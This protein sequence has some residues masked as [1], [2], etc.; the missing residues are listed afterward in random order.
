VNRSRNILLILAACLLLG[1]LLAAQRRHLADAFSL[2]ASVPFENLSKAVRAPDGSYAA[3]FDSNRRIA[4]VDPQ[5]E[6]DYLLA[7]RNNPDKGF[8]FANEIAFA[9][10][11]TL[12]VAST[13]I[14]TQTLAVNREAILRFSPEGRHDGVLHSIDHAPEAYVDNTGLFRALEWT[15][16]GLRLCIV[17]EGAI[18]ALLL[19]P[20]SGK[21]LREATHPLPDD[22]H[23][24]IDAAIV[25]DD[26]RIAFTTAA[27]E[28]YAASPGDA[29]AKLY[30]GREL[31]DDLFSIPANVRDD[32]DGVAFSDLGRDA[33]LRLLPDGSAVP[34]FDAQ[35]AA[36]AGY[37]DDY[38]ECKSFQLQADRLVL[39][40][41]GKIVDLR[42]LPTPSVHVLD[43]ARIN[44]S[45]WARRGAIWLQ[46]ALLAVLLIVLAVLAA[47]GS[48]PRARHVAG[49]IALV[50]AMIA[51]A[52]GVTTYMIFKNMNHRIAQEAADNL[53]GYLEVG[54]I[55]LDAD[56]VDRIRHVKHYGNDDYQAILRQLRQTITREGAI[57]SSTYSGVYK[58]VNGRLAALA[59][60][61]GL[62][63]IFYPY[64]YRYA[65]SV[66]AK[67]AAT[68]QP[69]LG[70]IVDQYGVWL[71]GVVPLANAQGEFVGF[72]EVGIDQSARHEANRSLIRQTLADLA[73]ILFVLLFVFSEIGFFTSHVLDPAARRDDDGRRRYDEGAIRFVSFLAIAGVF[74]SASFLPLFSKSLARPVGSL[75]LD[76][77]VGMPM[78][79]ETLCGA[80]VA[81][82]YG[83]VRLRLGLKT[84][85]VLACLVVAAGMA[86]TAAASSF[87]WL[88]AAR[89]VVGMGMG[90]LMIA[91]RT[92]FLIEKNELRKE[93]GIVAL[94][95]GVVAGIN[96]GSVAGGM[97]AA[98][99]GMTFV[100]YLQVAM[101]LLAAA[102]AIVLVRNRKRPAPQSGSAAPALSSFAFLRDRAVWTFFLFAFMPITACGL[103]LGFLFPLF[104]E[105]QGL[106][107]NEISLAFMLFGA[108]SV[109][110]GPAMTRLTSFLFGPRASIPVGALVM[111]AALLLFAAFQS[112]PAAYAAI[113]LFGLTDCFVFNQGMSYFAAL[114][115]VRRFG[116]DKA[117]GVYNVFESGGEALGPLAFGLAMAL[118]LG[119][120]IA[121]IAAT[122]GAC[123]ALFWAFGKPSTKDAP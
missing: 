54:R 68:G 11:G 70:E 56:A 83:H 113:A 104:A 1:G 17:R 29:P 2:A 16:A 123:A 41:N 51:A 31:P 81:L 109:Y 110:L 20:A 122:L 57:D 86:A 107:T 39:P 25:S 44:L 75:P 61:D 42:L 95:A 111:V 24:V 96:A 88:F 92:Y 72:L 40:N 121:A 23:D 74:L 35:I 50:A 106:S 9:P 4:K 76:L 34:L 77:L 91:F 117:M 49:Q 21:I 60:H 37:A 66:Y 115:G 119:A 52:V 87:P 90:L 85:V 38:Y 12:F 73:M 89:V 67:V 22:A 28:I 14:D 43:R 3:V 19:D 27:T 69:F 8:Y 33:I 7:S 10:D 45:L 105:S 99:T 78:V 120:G 46:S 26:L 36:A 65:D 114:P 97:I 15:P 79:V 80:V 58:I 53:R 5:G 47:R 32:G 94:T 116:E 59:Y 64:E 55:V 63:G 48:T 118:G 71:N 30:D 6:L 82:L 100:F 84:D 102:G 103:F 108:C 93:S 98:R 13:F 112:L 18:H 101:L 62:R